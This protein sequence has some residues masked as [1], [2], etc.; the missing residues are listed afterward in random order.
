M[1]SWGFRFQAGFR[2]FRALGLGAEGCWA[3]K[4]GYKGG[5]R[6]YHGNPNGFSSFELTLIV[7]LPDY[8]RHLQEVNKYKCPECKVDE[9]RLNVLG[10]RVQGSG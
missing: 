5:S 1:A 10:F 9:V 4:F 8:A 7:R 3:S 6:A 2:G